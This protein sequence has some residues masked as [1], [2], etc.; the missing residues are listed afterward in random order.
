MIEIIKVFKFIFVN[1]GIK[2]FLSK[3][4]VTYSVPQSS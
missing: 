2:K 1:S 3:I 4:N